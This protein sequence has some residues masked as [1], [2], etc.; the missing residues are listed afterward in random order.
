MLNTK[1]ILIL[2]YLERKRDD[3]LTSKN[4]AE[5]IGV[6]DKTARKYLKQLSQ[7][8]DEE[9]AQIVPIPGH[10]FKFII[11]D[12]EK[13]RKFFQ[14]NKASS[15]E[16]TDI[17]HIEE[18]DDRQYFILRKMFF[19][20]E[21]VT[22]ET[23]MVELAVSQS[24][25]LNDIQDINKKLKPY[26][27]SLKTSKKYG[28]SI[29]GKEHNKRHFIMNYFFVERVQNNLR[30]LGEISK[31][32]N[33]ISSEEILLIVLDECRNAQ[34][35]LNDTV[36]L[37]IVTH[38]ALALKRVEEGYQI[39]FE[40]NF[41]KEEYVNE[42]S[43]AINIVNRLKKSSAIKLPDEEVYNI[44]LHL[45]NK[46]S[47]SDRMLI[48]EETIILKEQIL[49]VLEAIQLD[50]GIGLSQ[51][52][53]LLNGL[54]DHFSPLLDR[55]NNNNKLSNPLLKEIYTNYKAELELTKSYFSKMNQMVQFNVSDDEWA[56]ISLHIIAA[57][58][59]SIGNRKM[60]TLVICATGLGSSQMLKVRLE[61][62]LGSKLNIINV[63]SYYEIRDEV[64]QDI[65]LI[66]SS[67]DLSNV[68]FNIPV[69]NVSVLLNQEDIKL[70]NQTIGTTFPLTEKSQIEVKTDEHQLSQ[71]I[72]EYFYSKLFVVSDTIK[73]KEEALD[74]L[75]NKCIELDKSINKQFL[76]GQ[77]KLRES[78]S[79]VVFS[80][81][82]AVPHPIEGIGEH[83]I[84][85][86]LITPQGIDW[87]E[88]SSDIK[89]TIL[90]IPDKYGDNELEK[91]SK[92]ILPIIEKEDYLDELV[93]ATSFDDFTKK[94]VWLLG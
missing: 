59:R 61:N 41:D 68:V 17:M 23:V 3:Y 74:T 86:I 67:I 38:I 6:T 53:I 73:N 56:Y 71:L 60:R 32:L 58:E 51:D 77:L 52:A 44:A 89:L 30:S 25:L 40:H 36:I 94:L 42:Y 65:D 54:I 14:I 5:H 24:T 22:F 33:T 16:K 81:S 21:E 87:D 48:D 10:G 31:L 64:L 93:K 91:V 50:T 46:S 8:I 1:E 57:I 12:K 18:S 90:M 76:M 27:L 7:S 72:K 79:T 78:F 82:V 69:V 45:K 84:V 29:K 20:D 34:L 19:E 9:L 15:F 88:N 2:D 39:N 83:P 66:I 28:L 11:H 4:I 35:K 63:I 37:N 47:K 26:E 49:K 70:I 85:G 75:T 55:L 80:E 43:T 13:Y 92:V 62:E